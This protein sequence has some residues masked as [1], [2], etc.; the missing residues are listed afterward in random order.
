MCFFVRENQKCAWDQF[1]AF[2]HFFRFFSRAKSCFRGN[3]IQIFHGHFV[4]HSRLGN[5]QF[6][7]LKS[8]F[9]DY[10]HDFFWNFLILFTKIFTDKFYF[11]GYFFHFFPGSPLFS[12]ELLWFFSRAEQFF[13]GKNKTPQTQ[14]L[15]PIHT[16]KSKRL[17]AEA[18]IFSGH[19]KSHVLIS[20]VFFTPFKVFGNYLPLRFDHFTSKVYIDH[21][22][23]C[24]QTRKRNEQIVLVACLLMAYPSERKKL[25]YPFYYLPRPPGRLEAL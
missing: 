22:K 9:N 15:K 4:T 1:F 5:F 12:R 21:C 14:T 25:C 7:N 16:H 2:S 23:L 20:I 6:Q 19:K 24:C 13:T 11:H 18:T 10:V 3:F 17:I 8:K